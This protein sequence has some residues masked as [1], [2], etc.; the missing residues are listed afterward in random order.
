MSPARWDDQHERYLQFALSPGRGSA[1]ARA[2]LEGRPV[3]IADV[4]I[5]PDYDCHD[6]RNIAD[7]RTVLGI[8]LLAKALRSACWH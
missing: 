1:I 6:V 7:Y 4:I 2:A 8:P 3:Q 5:Y